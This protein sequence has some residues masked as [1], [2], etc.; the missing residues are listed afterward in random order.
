MHVPQP[1][2]G[3]GRGLVRVQRRGLAQQLP[4]RLREPAGLDQRGGLAADCGQPP[5][6]DRQPGQLA[7]QLRRPADREIVPAGQV[8]GL[9][10][11]LGAVAGPRPHVR[12]QHGLADHTAARARLGLR[13]V[14]GHFRR[15]RGRDIGDLMPALYQHRLGGQPRPAAPA[16]GRANSSRSSGLSMSFIVVPGSPGCLPGRR[17]PRSRSDRSRGLFLYGLSDDGGR[18]EFDE[19]RPARRSR[20]STRARSCPISWYASA[21]RAASSACGS[22]DSSSAESTPGT[23]GTASKPAPSAADDQQPAA[24]CRIPSTGTPP[25]QAKH[26]DAC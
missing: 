1:A 19:S 23:S 25:E 5:G 26:P 7:Q 6:G 11:R 9:R 8:R 12:G 14:L 24:T 21:S 18:D 4:H 22:A 17:F 15:R 2:G 16:A 10:V 13:H 20:S 3:A